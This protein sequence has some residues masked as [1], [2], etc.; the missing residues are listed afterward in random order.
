MSTALLIWRPNE[1]V[2]QEDYGSDAQARMA[3]QTKLAA[4]RACGRFVFGSRNRQMITDPNGVLL[5][6]IRVLRLHLTARESRQRDRGVANSVALSSPPK[7]ADV[8]TT[9]E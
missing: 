9:K 6:T 8:S 2:R 7:R 1:V 5:E 4:H 3:L